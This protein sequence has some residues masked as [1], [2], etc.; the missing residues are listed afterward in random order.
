[1]AG[2]FRLVSESSNL[3]KEH[4][5]PSVE[6]SRGHNRVSASRKWVVVFEQPQATE[7][8]LL[9]LAASLPIPSEAAIWACVWPSSP[10]MTKITAPTGS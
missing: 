10:P 5:T 4:P 1:M 8:L 9:E 3:S 7:R 2:Q 6:R